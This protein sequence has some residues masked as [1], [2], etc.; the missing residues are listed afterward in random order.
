EPAIT[1]YAPVPP[2]VAKVADVERMQ[3]LVESVSRPAL[4]RFLGAWLPQLH[5]L[6]A[7]HR[8]LL[9]WAVDVDPLTI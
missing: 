7:R 5:G 1:V 8:G 9:R 3:M 2:A 6:R 4:Q